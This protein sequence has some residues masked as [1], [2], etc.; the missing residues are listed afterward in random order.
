MLELNRKYLRANRFTEKDKR[1]SEKRW[2]VFVLP[3]LN[4][5]LYKE[6]VIGTGFLFVTSILLF[7]I[8]LLFQTPVSGQHWDR[9][10]DKAIT[11]NWWVNFSAGAT[12]Y[13]GDLSVHDDMFFGKLNHESGPAYSLMIGKE[14]GR[15]VSFAGQIISG[16][17]VCRKE[18]TS[19]STN[20]FEYNLQ[21]RVNF[22][23]LASIQRVYRRLGLVGFAGVGN[24]MFD[25]EMKEYTDMIETIS[26]HKSRVP[27]FI[28]F[29]GGALSFDISRRF[30]VSSELSIRQCQNDKL[31]IILKNGDYDYYSYLNIGI[32]YRIHNISKKSNKPG[33]KLVGWGRSKPIYRPHVD[34]N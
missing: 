19:I 23:E 20:I 21:A 30:T 22:I 4:Q 14:M 25:T 16:N 2:P 24:F 32:T 12:S 9:H 34:Y 28:Y 17:M 26:T 18:N 33:E 27:E 6:Q 5:G 10:Y 31:D 3:E 7:V 1:F 15:F 11:Q 13:Y 29:F 8:L